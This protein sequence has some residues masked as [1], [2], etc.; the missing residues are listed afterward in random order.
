MSVMEKIRSSTDS[1]WMRAILI[2][3]GLVFV[4]WGVGAGAGMQT[5]QAV[6]LVNGTRITD[7]QLQRLMRDQVNAMGQTSLDEDQMATLSKQV[8]EQLITDE[9][10]L[11]EAYDAGIEISDEEIQ[12]YILEIDA[13]KDAEG[14]FSPEIYGRALKRLGYTKARFEEQSREEMMRGKLREVVA[15]GVVVTTAEVRDLYNRSAT[16]VELGFVRIQDSEIAGRV[17][18]T[19]A[20]IDAFLAGSADQVQ[21]AYEADKARLYS[22]PRRIGLHRILMRKGHAGV[23]DA[24]VLAR[25]EEVR[26]KAVAGEDFAALA[27]VWSEDMT[28]EGGGDAG[29]VPEPAMEP[30]L[31]S[32]AI[33]A[34]VGGLS[35]VVET[36]NAYVLI[37]VDEI[38]EAAVTPIEEVKRDIARSIIAKGRANEQATALAESILAAWKAEGLAP[39]A[40]VEESGL[41]V[42]SAGP[43]SPSESFIPGL[44]VAPA[45]VQAVQQQATTGV[46]PVVYP[47]EG[48]RVVAA[49]TAWSGADAERFEAIAQLVRMQLL[50]QKQQ[51]VLDQWEGQLVAGAKVERLLRN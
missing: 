34:G 5:T 50:Q 11:Q 25:M 36:D 2:I 46:L 45:L 42:Q 51:E 13:F 19:D 43:F 21:A 33:A 22:Q 29:T 26:A 16:Q 17:Q 30:R 23:A 3:I 40:L 9:V 49:V 44:G 47:V 24:D 48:G 18:V 28:A 31:A 1:T 15:S 7:T 6:A 39:A 20:E 41:R 8:L 4:F 32:A 38:L 35:T 27:R 10:L 14:A 12:R 37:R